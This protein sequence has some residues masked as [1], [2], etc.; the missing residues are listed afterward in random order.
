[1]I[2]TVVSGLLFG[3]L[4]ARPL[5][6]LVADQFGWRAVF[7][8]SALLMGALAIVLVRVLP[9]HGASARLSY[10]AILT[11]LL[12]LLR[13]TPLLQRRAAYQAALFGAFSLFWTAVPLELAGPPFGLTQRGIALFT[14]AGASGALAAPVAG[15]LADHGWTKPATA[16]ALGLGA[17][18][19]VLSWMGGHGSVVLL[20]LA[21]VVLDIGVQLNL[22]LGQRAILSLR[23]EARRRLNGLYMALF[24]TGG[25]IGS[26]LVSPVF[27]YGGWTAV[28][29]LGLGLVAAAALLYATEL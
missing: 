8:T 7:L 3:I 12:S 29:W 6:S 5:A 28:S 25:A 11:S 9:Q 10:R 2:G 1:V 27:V 19:F 13:T 14:L 20:A 18:A 16:V 23:A 22:V 15:W 21:G 24:F 4:L 17:L 26:A